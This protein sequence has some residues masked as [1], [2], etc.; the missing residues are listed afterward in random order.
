MRIMRKKNGSL[1]PK[2]LIAAFLMLMAFACLSGETDPAA[3]RRADLVAS[4]RSLIGRTSL[5]VRGKKFASDC[6]GTVMA[7]CW[8]AG[9]DLASLAA[10][11]KGANGVAR[12]YDVL[13][14]AGLL[15]P[16]DARPRIGDIIFWDDTYDKNG[17]GKADDPL[18]HAGIVVSVGKSGQFSYVHFRYDKGVIEERMNL[19]AP[20]VKD[21]PQGTR[22]NSNMR[23]KSWRPDARSLAGELYKAGGSAAGLNYGWETGT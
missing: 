1:A 14:R 18:T 3:K 12:I 5:F 8:G 7:A 10:K 9:L 4:A 16:K 11:A 23:I 20:A 19:D 22:L 17:N 2:R 13:S 6:S 21:G 15:L